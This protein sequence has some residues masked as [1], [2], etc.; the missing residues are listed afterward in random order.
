MRFYGNDTLALFRAHEKKNREGIDE[1]GILAALGKDTVVVHDHVTMNYNDDFYF[2]NAECCQHLERD[3]QKLF[4]ISGHSWAGKMKKLIQ[5]TIH[6][7]NL[8]VSSD[9][10]GFSSEKITA[11]FNEVRTLLA[12]AVKEHEEAK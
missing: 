8:L 5:Q 6:E 12:L 11:F 1:D 10:M 9:I 2:T 3:L 7:R 4:D